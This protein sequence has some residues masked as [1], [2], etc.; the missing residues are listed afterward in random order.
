MPIIAVY[1]IIAAVI[2]TAGFGSGWSVKDWKDGA[3][4]A[5]LESRDAVVTAANE[6]CGQDVIAV[7]AS[8]KEI[9]KA[10]TDREAAAKD[11]MVKAQQS[12][13]RHKDRADK[14]I[15]GLPPKPD[16]TICDAVEREQLEYVESRKDKK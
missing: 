6:K 12:A 15:Y 9:T 7:Q 13:S 10:A 16:E 8:V 11:A 3:K 2:F 4:I 14:I 5:Q 1:A